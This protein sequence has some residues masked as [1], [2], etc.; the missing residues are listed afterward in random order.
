MTI[1]TRVSTEIDQEEDRQP[2]FLYNNFIQCSHRE[3]VETKIGLFP[4]IGYDPRI[5]GHSDYT[6]CINNVHIACDNIP[7]SIAYIDIEYIV[8][9]FSIFFPTRKTSI[10]E[11]CVILNFYFCNANEMC[12]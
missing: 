10:F 11:S 8:L 12:H 9:F 4:P 6:A 7:Y 5:R 1:L 2:I 3:C